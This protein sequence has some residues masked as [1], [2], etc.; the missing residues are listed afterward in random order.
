[1][2][3]FMPMTGSNSKNL[4]PIIVVW[5]TRIKTLLQRVA[6]RWNSCNVHA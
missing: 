4:P 6:I 1:M 2:N 3:T 5:L